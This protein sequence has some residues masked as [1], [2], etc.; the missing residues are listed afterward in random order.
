MNEAEIQV[1]TDGSSYPNPGGPGGWAFSALWGSRQVDRFS[2]VE[3]ST[4]NTME[5]TAIRT[6]LSFVELTEH[7]M[8]IYTDSQYALKAATVWVHG[9]RKNG[10]RTADNKPVANKELVEEVAGLIALH[11][12]YRELSLSWVKGHARNAR[13]NYVDML[14]GDARIRKLSKTE[15]C[16][17]VGLP[18]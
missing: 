1:H 18:K 16:G 8:V 12:E 13:N 10:W 11:Q 4:N 15:G 9:W 17:R 3:S 14:A 6:A 5:L 2:H 7:S